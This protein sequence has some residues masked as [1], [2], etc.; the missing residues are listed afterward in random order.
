MKNFLLLVMSILLLLPGRAQNYNWAFPIAGMSNEVCNSI[1]YDA[2]GNIYV[3]GYIDGS[4]DFNPDPNQTTILNTAGSKDIYMA[5]YTPAGNLTW[6]VRMGSTGV[7][8]AKFIRIN[9]QNG[10]IYLAGT[11]QNTVDFDFGSPTANL[12]SAGGYDI[13]F[14]FFF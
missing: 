11:F 12:V 10:D 14:F 9:Q 3:A 1:A 7:D 4:A 13:F 2:S 8:E 5:K 6:A